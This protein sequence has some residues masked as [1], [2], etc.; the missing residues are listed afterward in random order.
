[1]NGRPLSSLEAEQ[2]RENDAA[3]PRAVDDDV[4]RAWA[5]ALSASVPAEP[6][7][8]PLALEESG[9]SGGWRPSDVSM[10]EMSDEVVRAG[11]RPVRTS[12]QPSLAIASRL[13]TVVNTGE[14]GRVSFVVDRSNAGLSIV[15]E[16]ASDS[17][18]AAVEAERMTL[19]RT[20]RVAGLTVLSF[21]VLLRAGS[22]TPLAH[23][24][25]GQHAKGV[26]AGRTRYGQEPLEED[27]PEN[28]DV[29][30]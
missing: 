20:L 2:S 9:S 5:A 25:N 15:V 3:E 19:L 30:G 29:V 14:L 27:D 10:T 8:R 28:V 6:L 11:G 21:R 16:V 18:A 1:M 22:G 4:R 26:S 13:E 24:A 7:A 17:A 23:R 12:S